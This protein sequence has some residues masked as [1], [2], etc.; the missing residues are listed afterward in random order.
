MK[1]LKAIAE[2]TRAQ[3]A[4]GELFPQTADE[5]AAEMGIDADLISAIC[6][7]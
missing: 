7:A 4:T 1:L 2:I 6:R 3:L 5:F